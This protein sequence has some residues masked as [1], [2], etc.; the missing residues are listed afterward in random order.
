VFTY[1]HKFQKQAGKSIQV[2]QVMETVLAK[3]S[4]NPVVREFTSAAL[5]K[6]PEWARIYPGD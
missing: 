2:M 5:D 3:Y 1:I 6:A 4:D